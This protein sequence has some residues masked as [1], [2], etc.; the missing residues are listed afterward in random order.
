MRS[1]SQAGVTEAHG[2]VMSTA[3]VTTADG[4][5][6]GQDGPPK[7]AGAWID[8]EGSPWSLDSGRAPETDTEVV[9]D[10]SSAKLGKL[11]L[12]DT[13]TITSIGQP[14][15]FTVVGIAKFAGKDTSGGATW[16]LFTLPT[17]QE[18]VPAGVW[19]AQAHHST[20]TK[21]GPG[22]GQ[23]VEG[24]MEEPIGSAGPA[25]DTSVTIAM[26]N[27]PLGMVALFLS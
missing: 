22:L 5:V 19:P 10:K 9:V 25:I 24:G 12:G 21:Q 27:H 15:E 1:P 6:I 18:F 16:S 8:S 13:V 7:F 23:M 20:R 26:T 2:D 4:T 3:T 14:R 11:E 17:A